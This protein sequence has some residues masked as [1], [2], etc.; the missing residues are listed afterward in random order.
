MIAKKGRLENSARK[1]SSEANRSVIVKKLNTIA[2]L[3]VE[4][5][6]PLHDCHRCM[7]DKS[8]TLVKHKKGFHNIYGDEEFCSRKRSTAL[9]WFVWSKRSV[10]ELVALVELVE[11]EG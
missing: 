9:M 3:A 2:E 8:V 6:D 1:W 11:M 4:S 10:V 5:Q 7:T